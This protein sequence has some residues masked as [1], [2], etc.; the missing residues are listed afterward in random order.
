MALREVS[1]TGKR[2]YANPGLTEDGYFDHYA[3]VTE[4]GLEW[5]G[6]RNG[7]YGRMGSASRMYAHRYSWIRFRGAILDSDIVDH[8]DPACPKTCITPGHLAI[9]QSREAHANAGWRRGE[10]AKNWET[11]SP[12]AQDSSTG[13]FVRAVS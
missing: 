9:Q 8:V 13:R 5:S 4:H 12:V 3:V 7:R 2:R 10:Y 11:R 1:V 6:P